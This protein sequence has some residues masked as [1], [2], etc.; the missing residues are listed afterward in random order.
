MTTYPISEI[1]HSFQGEGTY[2]GTYMTFIRLAGCN[3]GVYPRV[4][5]ERQVEGSRNTPF[6]LLGSDTLVK[7]VPKT[8][9]LPK[10]AG[11]GARIQSAYSVCT[12]VDGQRFM[13]DTDYHALL[14]KMAV[15]TIV[16]QV[17]APHVCISGGEPFL[18]DLEPL[19]KELQSHRIKVSVETSGTKPIRTLSSG[20][21]VTCCPKTGFD[22]LN[23]ELIDEWK[24]LV[25]PDFKL[26]EVEK[27]I[28]ASSKPVY[29]QPINYLNSMKKT[30]LEHVM[31]IIKTSH[32][33]WRISAQLHKWWKVR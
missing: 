14:G 7:N 13:C 33:E 15:D 30:N 11:S 25:G 16:S 1:F 28:G 3:V 26:E 17:K 4:S 31:E 12:T 27:I 6:K 20:E 24:F 19:L 2:T 9:S 29:L 5:S 18:H 8:Q 21:W 23:W 10:W 22:P 32:P